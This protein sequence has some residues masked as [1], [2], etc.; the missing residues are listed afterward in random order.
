VAVYSAPYWQLLKD[1]GGLSGGD[2]QTA[3]RWT[4]QSLLAALRSRKGR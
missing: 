2:A 3:V 1:R 4:M